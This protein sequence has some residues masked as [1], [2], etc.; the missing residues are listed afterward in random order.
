MT[1]ADFF[2]P[3]ARVLSAVEPCLMDWIRMSEWFDI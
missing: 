3:A 1:F 2:H